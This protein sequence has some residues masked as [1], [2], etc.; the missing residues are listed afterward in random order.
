MAATLF[1]QYWPSSTQRI[2]NTE[3]ASAVP[4]RNRCAISSSHV[5]RIVAH[6]LFNNRRCSLMISSLGRGGVAVWLRWMAS[7]ERIQRSWSGSSQSSSYLMK[8]D[9]HKSSINSIA[10]NSLI[11]QSMVFPYR[12]P[13]LSSLCRASMWFLGLSARRRSDNS[14]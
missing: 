13:S 4:S 10:R 6:A 3:S 11:V 9:W 7:E 14:A 2:S 5:P 1:G 8:K 12:L